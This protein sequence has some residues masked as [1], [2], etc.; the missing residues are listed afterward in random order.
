M[1]LVL[2]Y[3]SCA[4]AASVILLQWRALRQI[5]TNTTRLQ[6][7]FPSQSL[8]H[9]KEGMKYDSPL[10]LPLGSRF[11]M[12]RARRLAGGMNGP[13]TID[14][15]A[16]IGKSTIVFFCRSGQLENWNVN[17]F[18]AILRGC[19]MKVDGPVYVCFPS[20]DKPD[21]NCA[22]VCALRDSNIAKDVVLV[23]DQEP[24]FW[25]GYGVGDTPCAIQLD[26]NGILERY[27]VM[28]VPY[29]PFS[30]FGGTGV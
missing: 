2:V 6:H 10:A 18:M 4:V 20:G 24:S 30:D 17:V 12:C 15:A 29:R 25:T 21:L 5:M 28:T 7:L 27:G 16:L 19:W 1:N 26:R 13:D 3:A 8:R 23:L 9:G 11:P 22:A 14:S